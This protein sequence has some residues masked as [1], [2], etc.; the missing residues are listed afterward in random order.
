[1]GES[2]RTSTGDFTG[3]SVVV[4]GAIACRSHLAAWMCTEGENVDRTHDS[5]FSC[6]SLARL[7]EPYGIVGLTWFL[8]GGAL[9]ASH[10]AAVRN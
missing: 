10:F 5:K 6:I 1:M 4:I 3:R 9:G 7:A 2:A 8:R